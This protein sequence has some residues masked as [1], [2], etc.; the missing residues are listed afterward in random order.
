MKMVKKIALTL[1]V[2]PMLAFAGCG[3]HEAV[4][5]MNSI[6]DEICACKDLKCAQDAAKKLD[7]VLSVE[8]GL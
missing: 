3:E 4:K 5:D 7:G 2:V 8:D 6:A 1:C